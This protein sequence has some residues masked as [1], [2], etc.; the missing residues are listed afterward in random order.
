M[1]VL[2]S[3]IKQKVENEM[4]SIMEASMHSNRYDTSN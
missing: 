1:C 2:I 3:L 4:D